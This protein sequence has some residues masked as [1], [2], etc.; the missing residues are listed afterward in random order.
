MV[1]GAVK[2]GCLVTD[3]GSVKEPVV[4]EIEPLATGWNFLG[5]HPLAG[6]ERGGV[7]HASA[8][9]FLGKTY[10]LTPTDKTNSA[11][12][13]RMTTLVKDLGANPLLLS[14]QEHDRL[15]ALTSHL[16]H[17]A[18]V[19]I[20]TLFGEEAAQRGVPAAAV[21]NG[22]LDTTR[23]A[24]GDA[25]IW[26]DICLANA[27]RLL[28]LLE[29]LQASGAALADLLRRGEGDSLRERLRRAQEVRQRL[30]PGET[31]VE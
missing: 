13:E 5:G 1:A 27:Q 4:A 11:A 31:T 16:P 15:V 14:P 24:A 8:T 20:C 17:L 19:L 12:L 2:P 23:V 21:G 28:P 26:R 30:S 3:V 25:V 10:F 18:A 9:L 6:S 22:F 7:A 29:R